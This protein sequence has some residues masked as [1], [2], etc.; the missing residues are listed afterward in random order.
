[1]SLSAPTTCWSSSSRRR[2]ILDPIREHGSRPHI[3]TQ[4]NRRER[5]SVDPALYRQRN[6]IDRFFTRLKHFRAIATRYSKL[7]RNFLSAM[8]WPA[9][10]SGCDIMST[11]P[12]RKRSRSSDQHRSLCFSGVSTPEQV[13]LGAL[14][15]HQGVYFSKR[16]VRRSHVL[17]HHHHEEIHRTLPQPNVRTS[18][19]DFSM[20]YVHGRRVA[21]RNSLV[22]LLHRR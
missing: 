21:F 10:G 8:P 15:V 19:C 5:R 4:G 14:P 3:P 7:A 1:M 22:S 17:G 11:R 6:L 2:A 13:R 9:P 12:G 16:T 20:Q 18:A